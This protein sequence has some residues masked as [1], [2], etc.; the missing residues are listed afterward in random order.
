MYEQISAYVAQVRSTLQD[1][2]PGKN[3]TLS[4]ADQHRILEL[5]S[6]GENL[7]HRLTSYPLHPKPVASMPTPA[8]NSVD[9][10]PEEQEPVEMG[11]R[12]Y[13]VN[14]ASVPVKRGRGR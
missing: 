10:E 7:L 4:H 8:V 13:P 5:F 1:H 11:G 2:L 12:A 14:P 3:A 6:E 9:S